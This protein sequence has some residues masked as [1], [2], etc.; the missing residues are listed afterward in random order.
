ME[1]ISLPI[2]TKKKNPNISVSNGLIEAKFV[3]V[4]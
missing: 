2:N 1:N 4:F 3:T